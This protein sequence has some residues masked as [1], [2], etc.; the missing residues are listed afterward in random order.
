MFDDGNGRRVFRQEFRHK[1]VSC[2]RIIDVVVGKLFALKQSG[3][4]HARA[5]FARQVE[6]GALMRVFTVTHLFLQRAADGAVIRRLDRKRLREP[7]GNHRVIGSRAGIGL[8][9]K[10]LA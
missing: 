6:A 8:G 9:G 7:V 10:T 5:L 3:G 4:R 1:L 2:V